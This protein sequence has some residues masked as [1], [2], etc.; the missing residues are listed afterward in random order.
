MKKILILIVVL[1]AGITVYQSRQTDNSTTFTSRIKQ[2]SNPSDTSQSKPS[3]SV[4]VP[5]WTLTA[6]QSLVSY[7]ETFY[8]GVIATESGID[9]TEIGYKRIGQFI[10]K[11]RG[12]KKFL[13]VRMV[14]K[15]VNSEVLKSPKSQQSIIREA[16]AIAKQY[17]FDGVVFDFEISSIAFDTVT[18]RVS[19][20]Y[21]S[22]AEQ[23][24]TSGLAFYV[25]LYGDTYY[26]VR[27]YDVKHIGRIADKVLIMAYDFHKS[28]GNPGPTFPLSGKEQYGY[29]FK[30]MVSDFK[31]DVDDDKLTIVFGMFGYDWTTGDDGKSIAS[32]DPESTREIES[33]FITN[34]EFTKCS[35]RH[36]AKSSETEVV[37]R[38]GQGN[39]H[40]IWF[41]NNDSVKQKQA[42]LK[43]QG[44]HSTSFWAYT[45]Y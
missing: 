40:V 22:F 42:Y 18:K 9:E 27:A 37:Y 12:T 20:F 30:Q 23:T 11:A 29:D 7:N 21:D 24:K 33:R 45:Y 26:R 41:E 35:W 4:F 43:S 13:V 34:C 39:N 19:S 28:G 10:E 5:Y 36:D 3:T 16:N 31:K 25:T 8:F 14:D 44:I 2:T 38:D 6:E 1:V 17:G 32:G 15:E